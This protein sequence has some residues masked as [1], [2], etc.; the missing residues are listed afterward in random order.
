MKI[1]SDFGVAKLVLQ[2]L[3][4]LTKLSQKV[5]SCRIPPE[6]LE[7]LPHCGGEEIE[8]VAGNETI[9]RASFKC[10]QLVC[11]EMSRRKFDEKLSEKVN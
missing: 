5:L 7:H 1:D 6:D 10:L 2:Q 9:F 11:F 8:C 3:A 4:K